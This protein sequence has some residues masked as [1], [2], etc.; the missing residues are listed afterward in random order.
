MLLASQFSDIKIKY[1]T[2][3]NCIMLQRKAS[4]EKRTHV[5]GPKTLVL[6][7][8]YFRRPKIFCV[9]QYP[10]YFIL[11]RYGMHGNRCT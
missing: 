2:K 10:A 9:Q 7:S 6:A 3:I 8:I 11:P 5:G 4:H 1:T